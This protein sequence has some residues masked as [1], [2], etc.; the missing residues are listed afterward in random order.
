MKSEDLQ[1]HFTA[2]YVNLRI[3]MAVIAMAFP[4]LL[5]VGGL[6]Q[7][8]ELQP[9][10]SDYYHAGSPAGLMRDWFVGLLFAVGVFLYLYKGFT[11]A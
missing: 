9:S 6:L 8:L 2:T 5:W 7:G 11:V 3:G 1:K 10:M 4:I